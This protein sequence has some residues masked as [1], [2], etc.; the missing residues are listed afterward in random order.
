[1]TGKSNEKSP[2]IVSGAPSGFN[3][4]RPRSSESFPLRAGYNMARLCS[5]S[6]RR[7]EHIARPPKIGGLL[8]FSLRYKLCVA[9]F[10]NILLI[11]AEVTPI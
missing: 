4:R 6:T 11:G 3:Q 9:H 2:L 5:I 1:M 7:E 8:M 10:V